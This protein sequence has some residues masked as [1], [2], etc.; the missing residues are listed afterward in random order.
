MILSSIDSGSYVSP[1]TKLLNHLIGRGRDV[2]KDY[3]NY[4]KVFKQEEVEAYLAVPLGSLCTP[5]G[6]PLYNFLC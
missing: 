1:P 2:S 5:N 3:S 6:H 4:P